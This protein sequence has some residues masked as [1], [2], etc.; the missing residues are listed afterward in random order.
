MKQQVLAVYD[1]KAGAHA[2]PFFMATLGMAIRAFR[3]AA[4]D[5]T[6]PMAKNAEDYCLFHLGTW[7]DETAVFTPLAEH[8]NLGLAA[9]YKREV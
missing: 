7:D 9:N 8:K 4:N 2:I 3:E 5:A 1:S 6:H